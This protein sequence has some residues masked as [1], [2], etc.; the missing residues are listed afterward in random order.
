M[1]LFAF[2]VA[3]A[4]MIAAITLFF[5][6]DHIVVSGNERY[7]E[8]EVLDASGLVTGGNLYLINGNM[9]KLEDAGIFAGGSAKEVDT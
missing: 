3:A 6:M 5:R 7:S 8:Q 9:T 4:A 1:K 2:L